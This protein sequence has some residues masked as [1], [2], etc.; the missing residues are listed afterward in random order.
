MCPGQESTQQF[1]YTVPANYCAASLT[2]TVS[3]KGLAPNGIWVYATASVTVQIIKAAAL[4]IMM[5]T[6]NCVACPKKWVRYSI[7]LKNTCNIPLYGVT[8]TVSLTGGVWSSTPRP[9]TLLPGKIATVYYNYLVPTSARSTL[10]NTAT[11]KGRVG[12]T[13]GAW[14][15]KSTALSLPLSRV[16][17]APSQCG[18]IK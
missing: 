15:M 12:S 6:N 7:T 17:R 3:V 10:V 9:I 5:T 18:C 11:V 13:S 16:C 4:A 14:I 1:C 2:N 8:P